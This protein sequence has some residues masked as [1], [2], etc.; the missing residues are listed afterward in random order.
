MIILPFHSMQD[1]IREGKLI[2]LGCKH[3]H[4]YHIPKLWMKP[5]IFRVCF[6]GGELAKTLL[7]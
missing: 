4:G 3:I 2:Y 1:M 5:S 7:N 6:L